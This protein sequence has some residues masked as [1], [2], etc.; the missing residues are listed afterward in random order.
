MVA[1]R[2]GCA[3]TENRYYLPALNEC[4]LVCSDGAQ[5]SWDGRG[6]AGNLDRALPPTLVQSSIYR[7]ENPDVFGL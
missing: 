6:L 7:L 5:V 3:F 2:R 1:G 4:S